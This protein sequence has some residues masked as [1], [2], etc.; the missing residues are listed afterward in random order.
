M[1]PRNNY[2]LI[3][4]LSSFEIKLSGNSPGVQAE[5]LLKLSANGLQQLQQ[6]A[7]IAIRA[8]QLKKFQDLRAQQLNSVNPYD[9]EASD[10]IQEIYQ[11]LLELSEASILN[12]D[13]IIECIP[14]FFDGFDSKTGESIITD[15]E[16]PDFRKPLP[17]FLKPDPNPKG[18][19]P[20]DPNP[21]QPNPDI[22]GGFQ[23]TG[24]N[25][26]GTFSFKD[27]GTVKTKELCFDMPRLIWQKKIETNPLFALGG[28]AGLYLDTTK[29]EYEDVRQTIDK[30]IQE[31]DP[32]YE[33]RNLLGITALFQGYVLTELEVE[34]GD[35][36]VK[37]P[38]AQK[39]PT[40]QTVKPPQS[41]TSFEIS[42]VE[43][44]GDNS[45]GEST[46]S[47]F[48]PADDPN[49][50]PVEIERLGY[51]WKRY[52]KTE[53]G[54]LGA[55]GN[56]TNNAIAC[57]PVYFSFEASN[58]NPAGLNLDLSEAAQYWQ[59]A[60]GCAYYKVSTGTSIT[61]PYSNDFSFT[62]NGVTPPGWTQS[63]QNR[64]TPT[65]ARNTIRQGAA[66]DQNYMNDVYSPREIKAEDLNCEVLFFNGQRA[67]GNPLKIQIHEFTSPLNLGI[68]KFMEFD[69]GLSPTD[70][71]KFA[72]GKFTPNPARPLLKLVACQRYFIVPAGGFINSQEFIQSLAVY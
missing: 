65:P 70:A 37:I 63:V 55:I 28:A 60:L 56:T 9:A 48:A 19:D 20:T 23:T 15:P 42:S 67:L 18:L 46:K 57:K 58:L 40:L 4:A 53:L 24:G 22:P 8:E 44:S 2:S 5:Y 31:F 16:S 21:N 61:L 6:F 68:S 66:G 59:L 30:R 33:P 47:K 7:D 25:E 71:Y 38:F 69:A 54:I 52:F 45:S 34:I 35:V 51:K 13:K 17:D 49:D 32:L 3:E 50:P 26:P 62:A 27:N 14:E 12:C 10:S 41:P 72:K 29:I 36:G 39:S 11:S 43:D 1:P 64:A